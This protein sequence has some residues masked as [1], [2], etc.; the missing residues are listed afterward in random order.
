MPGIVPFILNLQLAKERAAEDAKTQELVRK[1]MQQEIDLADMKFSEMEASYKAEKAKRDYVKKQI[2]P[3]LMVPETS[4][5]EQ[6]Q[7]GYIKPGTPASAGPTAGLN[8]MPVESAARQD[9]SSSQLIDILTKANMMFPSPGKD[10]SSDMAQLFQAKEKM[11]MQ[12]LARNFLKNRINMQPGQGQP[13]SQ[14]NSPSDLIRRAGE[15]DPEAINAIDTENMMRKIMGLTEIDSRMVNLAAPKNTYKEG[16]L[17]DGSTGI[18]Q[19]DKTGGVSDKPILKTKGPEWALSPT[20]VTP[21]GAISYEY[22]KDL[23]LQNSINAGQFAIHHLAPPEMEIKVKTNPDESQEIVYTPKHPPLSVGNQPAIGGGQKL[24]PPREDMLIPADDISKYR[25][26]EGKPAR[27][28]MTFGQAQKEGFQPV[29]SG[30]ETQIISQASANE[31]L[32][33]LEKS[34]KKIWSKGGAIGR[35]LKAPYILGNRIAQY[36]PEL[37]AY[38][39]FAQGTMAPL[40]R[41]LGEKGN[42]SDTDIKRAQKLIPLASDTEEVATKKIKQ[43]KDWI[44]NVREKTGIQGGKTESATKTKSKFTI[45]EVR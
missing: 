28:G 2:V 9:I 16:L 13:S 6:G 15:G 26:A 37:S 35:A 7:G 45:I 29:S 19:I 20:Q 14:T 21:E 4:G 36:D 43:L 8:M 24:K 41:S 40:V 44:G 1:K 38:E 18:F 33:T 3:T 10:I 31:I 22:R 23:G 25:D 42:L 39:S 11:G 17:P 34:G 12:D 32:N 5:G 30:V 27:L